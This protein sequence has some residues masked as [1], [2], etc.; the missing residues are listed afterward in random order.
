[1][2]VDWTWQNMAMQYAELISEGNISLLGEDPFQ[3]GH[4]MEPSVSWHGQAIKFLNGWE[5]SAGSLPQI[6]QKGCMHALFVDVDIQVC[7]TPST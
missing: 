3:N 4:L 7:H 2:V 6:F 1:M 5:L